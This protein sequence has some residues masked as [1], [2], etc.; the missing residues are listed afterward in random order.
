MSS[1]MGTLYL[2]CSL[3]LMALIRLPTYEKNVAH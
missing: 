2:N 3:W 1:N